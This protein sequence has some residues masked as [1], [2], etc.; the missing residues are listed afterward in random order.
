MNQITRGGLLP[1]PACR[2]SAFISALIALVLLLPSAG[3]ARQETGAAPGTPGLIT[4]EDYV[5]YAQANAVDVH[6]LYFGA[7]L[8][9]GTESC[10]TCH[11]DE[12]QEFVDTGH[13]KWSGKVENI[14][15]LEGDTFG[16]KDLLN[17]FCIAVP[18]NEPRCSQ[19]HAGYGYSDAKFNFENPRNV[20]CLVCH[21][22]SGTY[23]KDLTTA[24]LPKA[25]VDLNLVA[26]SVSLGGAK[27]TRK[28]CLGCHAFAGGGDNVKHG[29]LSS[30][31]VATTREFDVHMG[32]DGANLVCADC[33]GANHDPKTG[34]VNHGG[35]GM[36]LH[37]V[38]EGEMKQCADCHGDRDAIHADTPAQEA[39][40]M[41][42]WHDRLACQT[43]HIPAIARAI[44]T[45]M[46][47]YWEDAGKIVSPIPRD[48]VT[49]R[50]T[51][52]RK[53]GTFVWKNN[54]RPELRF[55]N[56][57]WYRKVIGVND[58][59]DS[60]PIQLAMPDGD[61]NDSRAMIYPFKL[62]TGN[63][64]VD[65]VTG[66]I[67]VPHLFGK[68]GGPNPFWG[69]WDWGKALTDG[70]N[71]TGQSFSGTYIFAA[72]NMLLSVNHEVAPAEQA[73]GYGG[74]PD[75]CVSC[76]TTGVIDWQ[77]L[78]WTSDPLQGGSRA[79]T[80]TATAGPRSAHSGAD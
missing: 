37:S 3:S 79:G 43:C 27:P 51:F 25:S 13:F 31:L 38:H 55:S 6:E 49:G 7:V 29:D 17:N 58:T 1:N 36:S 62:M 64:P 33:H 9:E 59:Y 42:N 19:C 60:I 28:A 21:D 61:Y 23:E 8:Y 52:D 75:G 67:L 18:S 11:A 14:I 72:T 57:K 39:L 70:A 22:K 40:F 63:Q 5:E 46:E 47:W 65:P 69:T 26:S 53:K 16:K 68:G 30:D 56:G 35:A 78:G 24:G 2:N 77:A 54:V 48:P 34:Q 32:V 41:D 50:D 76:H 66:T 10:M 45:K 71:Y 12:A 73:L 44:S 74:V 15:G 20:D 4:A 80:T